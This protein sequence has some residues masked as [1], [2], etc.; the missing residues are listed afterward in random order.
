MSKE[1]AKNPEGIKI[2]KNQFIKC[3]NMTND[4]NMDLKNKSPKKAQ[5]KTKTKKNWT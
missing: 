1:F 3:S 2:I 4:A 5:K